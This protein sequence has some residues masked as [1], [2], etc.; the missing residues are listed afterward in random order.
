MGVNEFELDG[1]EYI[2][3]HVIIDDSI[4]FGCSGCVFEHELL[5]CSRAPICDMSVREDGK[6]VIFVE[7]QP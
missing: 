1:I 5:L 4:E 3:V 6:N 7:K 2:A